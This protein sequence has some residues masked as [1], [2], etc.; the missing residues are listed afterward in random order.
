MPALVRQASS[1]TKKANELGPWVTV[2]DAA[3]VSLLIY[4]L[5]VW[6]ELSHVA[7]ML[8]ATQAGLF[9]VDMDNLVDLGVHPDAAKDNVLD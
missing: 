7:A 1:T 6:M 5:E 4:V 9:A 3:A 2:Y 8:G